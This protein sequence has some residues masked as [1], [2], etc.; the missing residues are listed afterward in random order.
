MRILLAPDKFK[1]CLSASEVAAA[2]RQ[3]ALS[4]RPDASVRLLPIADGGEGTAE[5]IRAALGGTRVSSRCSDALGREI[6]GWFAWI[7]DTRTAVIEMGT[8]SGLWRLRPEERDPLRATTLGTGQLIA[9]AIRLSPAKIVVGLG[10]SATNDAGAGMAAALGWNFLTSDG[11]DIA[12]EP[13][14]F[15]SICRTEDPL[16]DFPPIVAACDVN[17]PLLGP[18]GATRVFGAQKGLTPE[19]AE[20]LEE[21]LAHLADL[22]AEE[23]GRDFRDTP[24]A[25]A[26]GG[27][28]FGLLSFCGATIA[29]GFGTVA[30]AIGLEGAVAASDLVITGEGCVDGQTAGGKGPAGV[31]AIAR[32]LGVPV[33]AVGGI[34][35][36]GSPAD[37]LFDACY[38]AKPEA[39]PLEE[40]LVRAESLIAEA[41]R[42]A[43]ATCG[44]IPF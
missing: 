35:Q 38:Q 28:G 12:P 13:R 8:A 27:L 4:A 17:N 39:M 29:S 5:T 40:A 31:A 42:K 6:E 9:A 20:W 21:S 30:D 10:G 36:R 34:V 2:M 33:V 43:V 1:G 41:T 44:H 16:A 7:P 25:G 24:G 19:N 3:G 14:N 23:T 18:C 26:A 22:V 32:R 37:T 11:E 15:F